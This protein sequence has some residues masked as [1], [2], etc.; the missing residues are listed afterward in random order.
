MV[1]WMPSAS[2]L[3][4]SM[5]S[6]PPSPLSVRRSFATSWKKM[7]DGRRQTED[8][9]SA[10]VARDA[11]DVGAV[12]GVDGD[13]VRRAVAPAVRAAQVDADLRHVGAAQVADDDVVRAPERPEV[14]RLDVV[15]VHRDRGDVAEEGHAAAVRGDVDVLRR[16]SRRRTASCRC[17]PAPR[18]CRCR[19]LGST[20]TRRRRLPSSRG[21]CHCR[22]R[23]SRRHRRRGSRPRPGC[24]GSC[25]RPR[26]RR[27]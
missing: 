23:R 2:R 6:S 4:A 24:R 14:D 15:E 25:R 1:S 12:G 26:R 22:R 19:R 21:R 16:C 11:D 8:V 27:S 10:R 20:G 13:R 9:D 3:V 7:F 17:R 5:T 18:W